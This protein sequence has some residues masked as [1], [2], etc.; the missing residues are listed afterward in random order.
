MS[1]QDHLYRF[2]FEQFPV[3][4]EFVRLQDSWQEVLNRHEY[5]PVVRDLLGQAMAATALLGATIKFLG[6]LIFQIQGDESG[7]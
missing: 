4:G 5:P 2:L 7:G 3:R 6:S 1:Q